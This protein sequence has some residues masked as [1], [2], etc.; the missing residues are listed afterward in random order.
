MISYLTPKKEFW[1]RKLAICKTVEHTSL[2]RYRENMPST[3]PD[4][5]V[6]GANTGP[7]W[8]LSAPDGPHVGPMNLAI[9]DNELLCLSIYS[10]DQDSDNLADDTLRPIFLKENTKAERCSTVYCSVVSEMTKIEN[11]RY[12]SFNSTQ[13]FRKGVSKGSENETVLLTHSGLVVPYN[14]GQPIMMTS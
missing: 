13:L 3:I 14:L 12:L 9:R 7:T 6:H 4:S 8:V 2:S 10:L 1:F 11:P 5:K